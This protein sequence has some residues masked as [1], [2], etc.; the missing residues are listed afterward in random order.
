MVDIGLRPSPLE[1]PH[2]GRGQ[3]RHARGF[4]KP[5]ADQEILQ[6]S[7]QPTRT[8]GCGMPERAA[9]VPE[10]LDNYGHQQSGRLLAR[11]IFKALGRWTSEIDP[12]FCQFLSNLGVDDHEIPAG[13]AVA[14]T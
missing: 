4:S 10:Q 5:G 12:M 2:V 9:D 11:N 8:D 7:E 3:A 1:V 13:S 14:I 6:P